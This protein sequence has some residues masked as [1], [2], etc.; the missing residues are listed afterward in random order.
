LSK[1][2][3]R[4]VPKV[5]SYPDFLYILGRILIL[6]AK[7]NTMYD[8]T[9]SLIPPGGTSLI[10]ISGMSGAGKFTAMRYLEDRGY[11]CAD[12]LPPSIIPTFFHLCEQS[13]GFGAGIAIVS[14]VR[15]NA[16]FE[17]FA[18]AMRTLK[19]SGIPC[20]LIF[21]DCDTDTLIRRFKE[22]RR[23]HPLQGSGRSMEEAIEE[24][25][26]RLAPIRSIAA[27]IIDTGNLSVK[28]FRK[29][30]ASGLF[31]ADPSEAGVVHVMSFGFKYGLPKDIDFAFDVRFLPN[32]FYDPD[33]KHKTGADPD[34]YEYVMKDPT[35]DRF[36][37]DVADIIQCT[38]GSFIDKGKTNII[39]GIG[40]TGGRH[41]STAFAIR[42]HN[43]LTQ[44]GIKTEISHRDI[45]KPQQ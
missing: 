35:A 40:C 9:P 36:F 24:E 30:L 22:V 26:R 17:E 44:Q 25:R 19:N 12:N 16:P 20:K 10:I 5:V 11:F 41:R 34:V 7:E 39:V 3:L 27:H 1:R 4:L 31:H 29:Q 42:L 23:S 33:M 21:L 14:D 15:S 32:P 18:E 43:H 45:A 2:N 37:F 38:F 28:D 13:S 8:L 6:C